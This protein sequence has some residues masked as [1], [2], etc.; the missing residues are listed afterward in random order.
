MTGR[1]VAVFSV[2]VAPFVADLAV[3]KL[4]QVSLGFGNPIAVFPGFNLTLLY[5]SG[6][7]FG[8]FPVGT[9]KGLVFMLVVQAVLS[10]GIAIYAWRVRQQ[11]ILWP[12]LLLLSGALANLVDR[13][14]NGAVTD[15]LDF[16][17]NDWHWPAF[18]LADV[19]ITL[20]V[21]GLIA[22]DFMLKPEVKT[23]L[24]NEG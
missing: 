14:I 9:S 4:A 15:Y 10:S 6:V 13:Y 24:K 22:S 16:Y 12:L 8:L 3:K 19:W 20:G 17:L 2:L 7:S 1:T 23:T 21:V 18:N 5:N 11:P